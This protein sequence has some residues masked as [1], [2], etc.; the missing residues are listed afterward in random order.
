MLEYHLIT[1]E[2][3][4]LLIFG[5]LQFLDYSYLLLKNQFCFLLQLQQWS[6][7]EKNKCLKEAL[8]AFHYMGQIVRL[9]ILF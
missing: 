4:E 1:L 9:I 5:E 3:Y 7:D 6:R 8:K 2:R